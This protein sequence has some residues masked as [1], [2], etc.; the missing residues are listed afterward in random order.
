M[1][2][3]SIFLTNQFQQNSEL[4]SLANVGD[5]WL[6]LV[7]SGEDDDGGWWMV[8]HCLSMQ[9]LISCDIL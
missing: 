6:H 1:F 3:I 7:L 5:C 4:L 2:V 9:V 8:L